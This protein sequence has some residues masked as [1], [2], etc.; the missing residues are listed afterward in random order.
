MKLKLVILTSLLLV[1]CIV[2]FAR[3]DK[4]LFCVVIEDSR[5]V[6]TIS[7]VNAFDHEK[8][9]YF[10]DFRNSYQILVKKSDVDR[11]LVVLAAIGIEAGSLADRQC[12]YID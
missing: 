11:S 1:V 7:A 8:I 5:T 12:K 6:D 4:P 10:V 2:V 3:T 9:R